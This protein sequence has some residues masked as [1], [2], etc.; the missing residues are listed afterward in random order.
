[1][2]KSRAELPSISTTQD[3]QR[4]LHFQVE[5][6]VWSDIDVYTTDYTE[7][8][9]AFRPLQTEYPATKI[10]I[11]TYEGYTQYHLR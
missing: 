11:T 7:A 1:M 5:E 8:I 3:L 4:L 9:E 10:D 2:F 6:G